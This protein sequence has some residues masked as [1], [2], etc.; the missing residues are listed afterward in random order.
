MFYTGRA[1]GQF[2]KRLAAI[3][4]EWSSWILRSSCSTHQHYSLQR[5]KL[6]VY[7]T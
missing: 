1:V 4:E 3:S 2:W 6:I 7:K 5:S